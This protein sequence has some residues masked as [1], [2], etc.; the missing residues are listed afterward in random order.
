VR[1]DRTGRLNRGRTTRLL[2]VTLWIDPSMRVPTPEP[3]RPGPS[4]RVRAADGQMKPQVLAGLKPPFPVLSILR[5]L[6]ETLTKCNR[7]RLPF[8]KEFE[9]LSAKALDHRMTFKMIESLLVA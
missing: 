4:I 2:I 6:R 3:C 5:V 7:P 9:R 8:R 1:R